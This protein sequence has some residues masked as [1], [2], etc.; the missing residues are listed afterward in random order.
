LS[1]QLEAGVVVV[2]VV[3]AA[4]AIIGS[5]KIVSAAIATY[6]PTFSISPSH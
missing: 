6:V 3:V 1:S 2:V 4:A 5:L